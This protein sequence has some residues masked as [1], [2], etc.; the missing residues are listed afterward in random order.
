MLIIAKVGNESIELKIT[1]FSPLLEYFALLM[2]I[3]K[4]T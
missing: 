3:L 1:P 4:F 2:I